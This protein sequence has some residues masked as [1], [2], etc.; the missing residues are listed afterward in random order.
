MGSAV[1]PGIENGTFVLVPVGSTEQHGP[2][3]PLDT[4]ATI[5][6]EVAREV[7]RCLPWAKVAPAIAF[8]SSGEHQD[9]PGTISIGQ[10][11]LRLMLI[12]LVRSASTWAQGIV[13]VNGHGG[14]VPALI[15]AVGQLRAEGQ[16]V[17]WV[18]CLAAGADAH[19]GFTE[20]SLMLHLRPRD[21]RVDDMAPGNTTPISALLPHLMRHG[22]RQMSPNGVL[23]DP[24]GATAERGRHL[25]ERMVEDVHA[26]VVDGGIEPNGR[27]RTVTAARA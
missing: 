16:E 23:G 3:L 6:A 26:A 15:S 17:A 4:D 9:F 11:A 20:T 25:F 1:W 12:E 19:A 22:V 24:T 18:P 7:A 21:V 10:D 14:N 2:H 8:G 13:F 27:L 5:A